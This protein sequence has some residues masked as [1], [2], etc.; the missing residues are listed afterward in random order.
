MVP[1][2]A[3][4]LQA[5]E[6]AADPRIWRREE[7]LRG[8]RKTKRRVVRREEASGLCHDA[9]RQLPTSL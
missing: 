7:L 8:E 5:A 9:P 2:L 1:C 3:V 4:L 6:D